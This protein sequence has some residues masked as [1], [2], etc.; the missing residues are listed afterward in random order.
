MLFPLLFNNSQVYAGCCGCRLKEDNDGSCEIPAAF[1]TLGCPQPTRPG[2]PTDPPPPNPTKPPPTRPPANHTPPPGTTPPPDDESPP[3]SC[4]GSGLACSNTEPCCGDC[5][6][7]AKICGEANIGKCVPAG[8]CIPNKTACVY[9]TCQEVC[10]WNCVDCSG[11]QGQLPPNCCVNECDPVGVACFNEPSPSSCTAT[12]V[13]TLLAKKTSW[14][15]RS[16]SYT[17]DPLLISSGTDVCVKADVPSG[18]DNCRK[19][20]FKN[21]STGQTLGT[22]QTDSCISS[23]GGDTGRNFPL[24]IDTAGFGPGSYSIEAT[25]PVDNPYC[26][27]SDTNFLLIPTPTG[28]RLR[29][30]VFDDDNRS[31]RK[32]ST[33]NEPCL[34]LVN[35]QLKNSK[36]KIIKQ[37]ISNICNATESD[38]VNF[39]FGIVLNGFYKIQ[40]TQVPGYEVLPRGSFLGASNTSAVLSEYFYLMRPNPNAEPLLRYWTGPKGEWSNVYGDWIQIDGFPKRVY[41]PMMAVIPTVSPI[42]SP[43]PTLTVSNTRWLQVVGGSVR[44]GSINYVIPSG[45][46]FLDNIGNDEQTAGVIYTNLPAELGTDSLGNYKNV[47]ENL[48]S[49]LPPYEL[50]RKSVDKKTDIVNDTSTNIENSEF[51]ETSKEYTG[52]PTFTIP[53]NLTIPGSGQTYIYFINGNLNIGG[54][55]YAKSNTVVFVVS[56]NIVVSKDVNILDGVYIAGGDFDAKD[57]DTVLEVNG[58]VYT[59][60][61]IEGRTFEDDEEPEPTYQFNYQPQYILPLLSYLGKSRVTWEEVAP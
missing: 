37:G 6:V 40:W 42:N 58:M 8:N 29:V 28:A 41:I 54:N 43:I 38:A 32:N 12:S 56:G 45:Y 19:I 2:A 57:G 20:T 14:N 36:G 55:I 47:T 27:G 31:A 9:G 51:S 4:R 60:R 25:I 15:C 1:C 49:G 3:P 26:A 18:N 59:N 53:S 5:C 52:S 21:T 17:D 13:V 48:P 33:S 11:I 46:K 35:L 16:M 22:W 44:K 30:G 10:G 39:D 61:F 23:Q 50:L 7:D 34:S 24:T